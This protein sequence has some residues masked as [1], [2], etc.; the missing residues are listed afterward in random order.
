M[1]AERKPVRGFS[2]QFAT[3]GGPID[4]DLE[5]SIIENRPLGRTDV[6]DVVAIRERHSAPVD[7]ANDQ[8]GIYDKEIHALLAHIDAITVE[9]E[10]LDKPTDATP[11]WDTIER[12]AV[13]AIL[14]GSE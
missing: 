4:P 11:R 14:R 10:G 9:M 12:A 8:T 2:E 13:L 6:T 1:G 5:R 3:L 7:S